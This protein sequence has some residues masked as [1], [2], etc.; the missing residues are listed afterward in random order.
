MY[1][2]CVGIIYYWIP[3]LEYIV[4]MFNILKFFSI[5]HFPVDNL[6]LGEHLEVMC[7]NL[8]RTLLKIPLEN[9]IFFIYEKQNTIL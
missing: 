8:I 5:L 1:C 3:V 6:L 4:I 9:C 7:V 2:K